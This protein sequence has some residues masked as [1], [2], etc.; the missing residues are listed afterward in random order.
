MQELPALG[1]LR[2][3][4]WTV[5]EIRSN[6]KGDYCPHEESPVPEWCIFKQGWLLFCLLRGVNW[7][8]SL[9]LLLSL[10]NDH[11]SA[12]NSEQSPWKWSGKLFHFHVKTRSLKLLPFVIG[13]LRRYWLRGEKAGTSEILTNLPGFPDNVR[14]NKDGEFWVAIHSRRSL[15]TYL[16][17]LYPKVRKFILGLP[18]PA[19]I[20]YLLHIGGRL[21]AV[22]MKVSPEGKLLQVLEDSQGKVVRAVSEVEERDGKLWMGS[23]L[24]PFMALYDLS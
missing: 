23:V 19:K 2:R 16:C 9:L 13:R 21:H 6:H 24:M 15:Y 7:S 22:V 20:Q 4:Q 17:A 11:I 3:G 12:I 8:V 5:T 1:F 10:V 18:I 14:T